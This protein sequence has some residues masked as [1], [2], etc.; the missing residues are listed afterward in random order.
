M[1][2]NMNFATTNLKSN[3]SKNNLKLRDPQVGTYQKDVV[4]LFIQWAGSH[5]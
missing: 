5:D 1:N 2:H 4:E 3:T